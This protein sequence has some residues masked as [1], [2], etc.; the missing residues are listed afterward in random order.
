M[1]DFLYL[2]CIAPLEFFMQTILNWG[3]YTTHSFG[4]ALILMSLAVNTVILPI[5]N[6]VESWQEEERALK[7][8]MA[9]METMIR[10]VFKGQERFA[11]LSTLYRQHGYS[12][13]MTLR[14]SVG[15][16]LQVPFFFAA[17][18]LLSHMEVL[19]GVTFG[20]IRDLGAPDALFSLGSA[21]VNV[22][23]IL[24]T[25]V[26]LV[27]A[28]FYT[29]GLSRRDKIQLYGM[30]ALFLVL[31]YN[32]PAAL[33]FYW[34]LNNVYSLGKNIV[35]KD[36]MKRPG[37]TGAMQKLADSRNRILTRAGAA[38][39]AVLIRLGDLFPFRLVN[40]H[41][42]SVFW[43]AFLPSSQ[44]AV[45]AGLYLPVTMLIVMLLMVYCPF[46]VYSS[47]PAVFSTPVVEFTKERLGILFMFTLLFYIVGV[48]SGHLRWLLGALLTVLG[49]AALC[50]CFLLAPDFGALDALILQRPEPL[51]RWY[52]IYIDIIVVA[53]IIAAF[54]ALIKIRKTA[55]LKNVVYATLTMLIIMTGIHYH[56]SRQTL[57]FIARNNPPSQREDTAPPQYMKDFFTFSKNGRNIVVVMLDMFTGGNMTQLFEKYPDLKT[58][59]DGFTWYEDTVTA[60]T[61][62]I[63][64]KPGILGG[65]MCHPVVLNQ[66]DSRSLEEK[67]NASYGT[68]L[69]SLQNKNFRLSVHNG[70]AL[71]PALVAPLLKKTPKASFLLDDDIWSGAGKYW[72]Q[73]H[74][75][76]YPEVN[77]QDIVLTA[78]GLFNIAPLS[79]K[80]KIYRNGRWMS[81]VSIASH[82]IRHSLKR[83]ASLYVLP[84]AS[85]ISDNG[86]NAFIFMSNMLT[87]VPWGVDDNGMPTS[88]SGTSA[89]RD[90]A[91]NGLSPHHLRTEGFALRLLIRWFDWMKDQGVYDN[92]QIIIVSDHG[93][94]DSA[95]IF[96]LWK[97]LPSVHLHGLLLVKESGE[98]GPVRTD[99]TSLMANWDVPAIIANALAADKKNIRT[100]WLITD[101]K[102]YHVNGDINRARHQDNRFIFHEVY[103]IQGPLF[104]KKSWIKVQ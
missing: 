39:S 51:Y 37:W 11:M 58:G 34:T 57:D 10:S 97:K 41:K 89:T 44:K 100:P 28:F 26:N 79:V 84:E 99:G 40:W 80:K 64:G 87:H 67:I 68:F 38:A 15:V 63:F 77:E 47:D 74:N 20:P 13:F 50:F 49:F 61:S 25:V 78:I 98:R 82:S 103:N 7:A 53:A 93:R 54:L 2:I 4:L 43:N 46:A 96:N 12:Q 59:L 91:N 94:G 55:V 31:L 66:D 14:A 16:L 70:E 42:V 83:L 56:S 18:H 29:H 92:T 19:H 102:R 81:A 9:P 22:L 60:G 76:V 45:L 90:P 104:D 24:M 3:F 86:E 95:K 73:R 65:E 8:R 23:P 36:W 52:N 5:Y 1:L 88:D 71:V 101:R 30:A 62:T 6:K 85:Q 69:R 75:F 48:L 32:S 35:E 72:A 21:S 27:S 17:Y 33:T